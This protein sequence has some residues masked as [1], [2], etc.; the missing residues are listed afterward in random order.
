ME[1]GASGKDPGNR[2]MA[3]PLAA[4]C[5][6][7]PAGGGPAEWG[8]DAVAG[9]AS[10]GRTVRAAA[11]CRVSTGGEEQ[12]GSFAAQKRYF[13]EIIAREPAWTL[14]GIYADEGKSG[15]DTRRRT[16][17]NR[18]LADAAAG[19]FTLLLT[20]EVSRFS[21][22]ILDTIGCVRMLKRQGVAV[23]FLNDG[24]D[25]RQPD[26]ELRLSIM[27]SL[28][29]EESR[30]T[31]ERVKWGQTRQMER[32][33]VF[34]RSL[35]G[36]TVKE[37]RLTVEPQGA[38]TVRRIYELYVRQ[39]WGAERI[40]K[41][42][43]T[44]GYPTQ[45]GGPWRA[46][47]VAK[48][49]QNEKYAG[50]LIQKKSRTPDYLTHKKEKNRGEEPMIVLRDHH[51]GIIPREVWEEAQKE[52][53]RRRRA[54]G[55]VGC[56]NRFAL[57][58]KMRCGVCGGIFTARRRKN[59]AGHSALK[60]GCRGGCGI[61]RML[62]QE[63][64][65]ELIAKAAAGVEFDRDGEE[66]RLEELLQSAEDTIGEGAYLS[67]LERIRQ[68]RG[69]MW[70]CYLWGEMSR[71][72]LRTQQ[73]RLADRERAL[74]ARKNPCGEQPAWRP[75]LAALVK[76]A[77]SEAMGRILAEE[78]VVE[79]NRVT[80]RMAGGVERRFVWK[81]EQQEKQENEGENK[82]PAKKAAIPP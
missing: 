69:R 14:Y 47:T 52:R 74:T 24:I 22:N 35:L 63:M 40:A 62:R 73:E 57:S 17:F 33:V 76:G 82:K 61:G 28:A 79:P 71:E 38:E 43:E 37:G 25:T 64:A 30:R 19:K 4:G 34:G 72:E 46:G 75:R 70:E 23:I 51:E 12:A 29:Q 49:L 9:R 36:Y 5:A 6:A 50:D 67:G 66:K 80:V 59:G 48:I 11:Y 13:A 78:L 54:A 3:A 56:A 8:A 2:G 18:M 42:L 26:A 10:A 44:E 16:E 55:A 68:A 41:V 58:G 81:E 21:R 27:G 7:D 15:T 31:S 45:N 65:E 39:K 20:K 60:W 53:E 77:W 32:G 1:R